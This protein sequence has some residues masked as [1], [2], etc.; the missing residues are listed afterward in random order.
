MTTVLQIDFESDFSDSSTSA[1]S[2]TVVGS[3]TIDTAT[4][5][6]G[7]GSGRFAAD[8]ITVDVDLDFSFSS[9]FTIRFSAD[10]DTSLIITYGNG[11]LRLLNDGGVAYMLR[12]RNTVTAETVTLYGTHQAVYYEL[13]F[14]R[15]AGV[16]YLY[17]NGVLSESSS[18]S[19]TNP[20]DG[21]GIIEISGYDGL[22][23]KVIIDNGTALTAGAISYVPDVPNA[24]ASFEY[25]E[26]QLFCPLLPDVTTQIIEHNLPCPI[27]TQRNIE[28]LLSCPIV[29]LSAIEHQLFCPLNANVSIE[30]LLKINDVF[31][32]EHALLVGSW[33][34]SYIEHSLPILMTTTMLIEQQL[35]CPIEAINPV[36]HL[37]HTL[38]IPMINSNSIV[39]NAH[40]PETPLYG[41][42]A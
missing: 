2:V 11:D 15:Y 38:I 22:I 35:S 32:S 18:D 26:H 14:E 17:V 20:Y 40:S 12:F 37:E 19:V 6:F 31:H 4:P 5:L 8:L 30:H 21:T 28:Q 25:I 10:S 9:D 16:Y 41:S 29:S 39:I 42:Y 34:V 27:F 3:P 36:T 7:V 24:Y 33:T 13:S 1:H 23:D